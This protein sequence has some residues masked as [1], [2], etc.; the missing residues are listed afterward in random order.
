MRRAILDF[1]NIYRIFFKLLKNDLNGIHEPLGLSFESETFLEF[2]VVL[3][4]VL[5]L[6][7]RFCSFYINGVIEL[8]RS[9]ITNSHNWGNIEKNKIEFLKKRKT[10]KTSYPMKL[11]FVLV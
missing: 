11:W 8:S 7:S 6:L 10:H 5:Y 9:F 4:S 3:D 2:L 1:V